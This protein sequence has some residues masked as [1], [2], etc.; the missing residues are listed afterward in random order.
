MVEAIL[1][2]LRRVRTD[3]ELAVWWEPSAVAI[4][5]DLTRSS[6]VIA[7][8]ALAFVGDTE[9]PAV[10]MVAMWLVRVVVAFLVMPGESEQAEREA[11]ERFVAPAIASLSATVTEHSRPAGLTNRTHVPILF[12]DCESR[13]GESRQGAE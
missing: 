8:L 7:G 11:L 12:R 5:S 13:Q 10:R 6:A 2:S 9:D 3:P 1:A 4:A